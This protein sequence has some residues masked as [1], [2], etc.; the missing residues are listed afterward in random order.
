MNCKMSRVMA[1]SELLGANERHEAVD[2]DHRRKDQPQRQ[3][4]AHQSL[5]AAATP[6]AISAKAARPPEK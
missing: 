3:I 6:T 4:E 2:E 1:A 5:P